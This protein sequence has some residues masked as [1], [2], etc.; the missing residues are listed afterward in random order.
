MNYDQSR[1]EFKDRLDQEH[2]W[3]TW[4]L[5]KFIVPRSKESEVTALFPEE[6]VTVKESSKG[7]YR[8]VSVK[9]MMDSS[10]SVMRI[11]EMA[12]QIDGIL[13]L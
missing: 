2:S 4:Y 6:E 12:Y 9:M 8:S 13:A 1:D 7:N 10:E 5:F 3:P 11:Y